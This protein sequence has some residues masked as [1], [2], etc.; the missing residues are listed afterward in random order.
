MPSVSPATIAADERGRFTFFN[1]PP[2]QD[3][4]FSGVVGS[5]GPWALRSIVRTVGEADS[6]TALPPLAVERGF[7]LKGRVTLGDG[8]PVPA[9][10]ELTLARSLSAGAMVIPMDAEGRFDLEGIPP[11]TVMLGIRV[12]GYRL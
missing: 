1:V 3:H 10:T 8:K 9:G 5:M 2:A 4:V 6:V 11:E 7:R 12:K